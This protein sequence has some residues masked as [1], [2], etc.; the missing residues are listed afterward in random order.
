M[1]GDKD[2]AGLGLTQELFQLGDGVSGE[3]VQI[4]KHISHVPAAHQIQAWSTESHS[5]KG[6][7]SVLRKLMTNINGKTGY[8]SLRETDNNYCHSSKVTNRQ[9]QSDKNVPIQLPCSEFIKTLPGFPVRGQGPR[10]NSERAFAT[11]PATCAR[12]EV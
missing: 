8:Q 6:S 12:A 9:C 11:A 1:R 10:P 3:G 7:K 2:K 5:S 4:K